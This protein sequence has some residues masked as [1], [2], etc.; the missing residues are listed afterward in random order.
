[1]SRNLWNN[2]TANFEERLRNTES[3]KTVAAFRWSGSVTDSLP[4]ARDPIHVIKA[5][6]PHATLVN[7]WTFSLNVERQLVPS[8]SWETV[9]ADLLAKIPSEDADAVL[10]ALQAVPESVL[11]DLYH[12]TLV[13]EK[14]TR[15]VQFFAIPTSV[16]ICYKKA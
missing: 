15:D 5:S 14:S 7:V 13:P 16:F 12:A 8:H 6:D 2:V 3:G 4:G 9:H 1:M 10:E 11:M